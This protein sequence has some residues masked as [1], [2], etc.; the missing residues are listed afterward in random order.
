M[1]RLLQEI[2][3]GQRTLRLRC[4]CRPSGDECDEIEAKASKPHRQKSL[5]LTVLVEDMGQ[6][7]PLCAGDEIGD[8]AW[9]TLLWCD[10][11]AMALQK[12]LECL[13]R[14]D[15]SRRALYARLRAKG[16]TD[17]NARFAVEQVVS[18]GYL[19]EGE[20]LRRLCLKLAEAG[21]GPRTVTARAAAAGYALSAAE[22][23]LAK[24]E[25]AGEVDFAA[26]A[27]ALAA[28]FAAQGLTEQEIARK[29]YAA[30]FDAD[31]CFS[32]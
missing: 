6:L 15:V 16:A 8:E 26:A 29:L 2:Q 27:R 30:G 25:A 22:Q 11:R 12:A 19:R 13:S 3:R 21:K 10:G 28:R 14:T 5:I 4:L 9:Q 23:T 17:D 31:D 24:L 1:T 7:P 20:Q 32:S 18:L